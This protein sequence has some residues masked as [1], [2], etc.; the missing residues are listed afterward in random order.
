MFDGC[1]TFCHVHSTLNAITMPA[2]AAGL[3]DGMWSVQKL[4]EEASRAG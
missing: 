4:L 1:Y 2:A 3:T